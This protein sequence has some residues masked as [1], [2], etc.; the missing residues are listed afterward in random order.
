MADK[1]E[2]EKLVGSNPK[3]KWLAEVEADAVRITEKRMRDA[4]E[5]KAYKAKQEKEEK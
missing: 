2:L 4:E 3:P 5:E 1:K